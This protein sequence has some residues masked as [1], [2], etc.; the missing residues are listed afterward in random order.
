[1]LIFHLHVL[2]QSSFL[3]SLRL[4]I[5]LVG[6]KY[7]VCTANRPEQSTLHK[8]TQYDTE[9]DRRSM[10]IRRSRDC[11][12]I[13][14]Q[15]R[16]DYHIDKPVHKSALINIIGLRG[17]RLL[18]P[19]NCS[20][21]LERGSR[22]RSVVEDQWFCKPCSLPSSSG[23]MWRTIG[24]SRRSIFSM[25]QKRVLCMHCWTILPKNHCLIRVALVMQLDCHDGRWNDRFS[26][27]ANV[28]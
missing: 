24:K 20:T 27:K 17:F 1:M 15:K 11:E 4:Y 8:L 26:R 16:L 9:I 10:L 19:R 12:W 13:M 7:H 25:I 6:M 2:N 14:T 23:Q 3:H 22:P 21:N 18:S 5:F 28:T